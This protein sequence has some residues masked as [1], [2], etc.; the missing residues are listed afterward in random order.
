MTHFELY[1]L[2][3]LDGIG[4]VFSIL[5][6]LLIVAS[7]ITSIWWGFAI[8]DSCDNDDEDVKKAGK[9]CKRIYK[10]TV[11][12]TII[13][14]LTPC[15]KDLAIIYGLEYITNNEEAKKLPDNVLKVINQE[16]EEI[17]EEE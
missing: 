15:K 5:F 14:V 9:I 1:L 16:L 12:V 3:R 17:L 6:F 10:A 11:I 2:T 4:V 8:H 13:A 7:I